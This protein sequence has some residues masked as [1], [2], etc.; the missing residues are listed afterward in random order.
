MLAGGSGEL[1][2]TNVLDLYEFPS[3]VLFGV[4]N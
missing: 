3:G 1:F 4:E 2:S